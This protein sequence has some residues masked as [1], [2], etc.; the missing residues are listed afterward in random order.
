MP[1]FEPTI[2]STESNLALAQNN[3]TLIDSIKKTTD[4]GL[5]WKTVNIGD[6]GPVITHMF[7][8]TAAHGFTC[9]SGRLYETVDTGETWNVIADRIQFDPQ[10]FH[11]PRCFGLQNYSHP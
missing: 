4:A 10:G 5:S 8:E 7:F 11:L 1:V 2:L 9:G 6:N 3:Q